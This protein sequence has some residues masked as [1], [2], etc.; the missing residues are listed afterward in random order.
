[1]FE[2]LLCGSGKLV[3][4]RAGMVCT[5]EVFCSEWNMN[6]LNLGL[7][8]RLSHLWFSSRRWEVSYVFSLQC[9]VRNSMNRVT[10]P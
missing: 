10:S 4:Q 7:K 1:M 8:V 5:D 3:F 6:A 2:A 9:L